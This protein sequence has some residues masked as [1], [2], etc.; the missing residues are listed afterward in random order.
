MQGK[1]ITFYGINNIGKTTHAKRIVEHLKELGKKA[2]Y[3]K[4]P[5]YE[6]NPSGKFLNKILR[7]KSQKISEDELQLWFVINRYQYQPK[8]KEMLSQGTWV[9]AEDYI[10]TGIA[11]GIT[12]GLDRAWAEEINKK[13]LK[14]DL[15]ILIDGE[16]NLTAKERKHIHEQDDKLMKKSRKVHLELGKLYKW[17]KILLCPKKG[18]TQREIWK[19]LTSR[20]GLLL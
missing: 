16:R 10:G 4:Y 1:F 17:E 13:L 14:E 18:D 2:V 7:S 11:W 19:S 8:I 20:L 9:I 12:K 6:I 3:V 15:A 5:V